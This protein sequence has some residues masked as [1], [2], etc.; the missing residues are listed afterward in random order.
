MR[1]TTPKVKRINAVVEYADG[2]QARLEVTDP[3]GPVSFYEQDKYGDDPYP[4]EIVGP[5]KRL[6]ITG[7]LL[8]KY[9]LKFTANEA[10]DIVIQ[11][12]RPPKEPGNGS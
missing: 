6:T 2:T 3:A 1:D 5:S 8:Q 10:T 7:F 11:T 12:S 4:I 9:A